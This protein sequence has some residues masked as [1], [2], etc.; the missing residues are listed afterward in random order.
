LDN[1]KNSPEDL[2]NFML[3][4][5]IV[6]SPSELCFIFI[7]KISIIPVVTKGVL[8]EEWLYLVLTSLKTEFY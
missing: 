1:Q 8:N 5:G 4:S 7:K 2:V 3:F 6:I